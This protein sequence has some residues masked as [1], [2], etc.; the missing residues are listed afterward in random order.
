MEG[1]IELSAS[2]L[3]FY[4]VANAL[5]Y[6]PDYDVER[7]KNAISQLFRLNLKVTPISEELLI[8]AC[9]I[10]YDT[11]LTLYDALPAA[12][13]ERQNTTCITADEETQYGKLHRR[14]YPIELL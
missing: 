11:D 3:L 4:E 9:E 8:R 13:A 12:L 1:S 5:G 6:K 10:A 2:E 7:L 14:G